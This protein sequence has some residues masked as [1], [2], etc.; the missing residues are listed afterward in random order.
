MDEQA[1]KNVFAKCWADPAFKQQLLAD[2][3]GTLQAEG[4]ELPEGIKVSAVE[5][6]AEQFT[7]VIPAQPAELTDEMLESVVGGLPSPRDEAVA[8]AMRQSGFM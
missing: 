6:N 2:P 4:L 5:N 3:A 7:F 8:R 1:Y